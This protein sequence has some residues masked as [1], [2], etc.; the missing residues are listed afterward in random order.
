MFS[1]SKEYLEDLEYIVNYNIDW[2][3][4]N[5]SNILITGATGLIGTVLVDALMYKNKKENLNTK[6]FALSRNR[7]KILNH[8]S[9]Y[10][11]D[12]NLKII[13]GDV[14]NE[15]IIKEEVDY[16]INLA[17]NTHPVL[18]AT[19]PISTIDSIVFGTKN[20]LELAT[21]KKVR[22]VINTSSVEIYGE[23]RGDVDVFNEDYCGYINC[24]T[25]RAGYVE[26]KRLSEA[27]CQ[28]YVAENR[29]D[30]VSVRLGRI[31][32]PTVL[33]TD[34]KASTQ[35]IFNSV[36]NEDIVL[37]SEGKQEYSYLYVVDAATAILLLLTK[38]PNG[39]VYN[40][41]ND[42]TISLYELAK[43]LADINQKKIIF[44]LPNL[45]EKKGFSVVQRAL[46]S[47]EKIKSL[48]WYANYP[49]KDGLLRTVSIL[50]EKKNEKAKK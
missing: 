2:Q 49:L 46:M 14:K 8:F 23:N 21:I 13:V 4:I 11:N 26:G 17:S 30:A 6:I 24:N 48:G 44:E 45:I 12:D 47:S 9:D 28:A 3:K 10:I 15:I 25:L 27:F 37:K 40:A 1:N 5:N 32:G 43:I 7:K 34:T 16:I 36:N 22:R 39:E 35:F 19:E 31:Y 29:I 50:K 18:Y 33:A 42:E 20:I 38:C 41:S